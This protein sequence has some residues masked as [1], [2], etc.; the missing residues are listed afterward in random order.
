MRVSMVT[1]VTKDTWGRVRD[2]QH[3]VA[4]DAFNGQCFG[5][6]RVMRREGI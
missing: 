6:V 3:E 4:D 2:F 1:R 5:L